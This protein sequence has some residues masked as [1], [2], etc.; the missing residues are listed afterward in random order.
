MLNVS[1]IELKKVLKNDLLVEL[2]LKNRVGK[3]NVKPGFDGVYG[4]AILPKKQQKL[5]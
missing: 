2:I 5:F 1:P 3:I 4:K